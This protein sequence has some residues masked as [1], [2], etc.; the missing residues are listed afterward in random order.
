MMRPRCDRAVLSCVGEAFRRALPASFGVAMALTA[1]AV[2][3]LPSQ[4]PAA[5]RDGASSDMAVTV[6][7]AKNMCFAD[8]LQMSG[9]LVPRNEVLVRPEREGLQVSQVLV[10]PGD[11][12]VSGQVLARLTPPDGQEGG[13]GGGGSSGVAVRAPAAGVVTSSAAV[14]GT[15]AS[16]RA[17]P[18]FRIA[19]RGEME[20]LADTP[21]KTLSSLAVDQ[22]AKVEIVGI[23]ELAGKVRLF[24]TTINPTT[25]L[26][27][28]RIFLGSDSRLRVG[29]FGRATIQIGRR[30]GPAVPLSAVL[31]GPAGAVVQVARD[32]RI[33][34]RRVVVGLLAQ[35][36]AEIREGIA[37]GEMVVTRAGAFVRDGDR[38]RAVTATETPTR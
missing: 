21:V 8:T 22:P 3:A 19:G 29:A 13:G 34:T 38:V 7:A 26:G 1:I 30:C 31:Y 35:G 20:L 27:Q 15:M 14:V 6:V 36:Q 18:L 11:T 5:E 9:V 25:Q 10:E 28:V 2:F 16:A 12:I 4:S 33:E 24:S 23:G 37:D 17:E 32:G